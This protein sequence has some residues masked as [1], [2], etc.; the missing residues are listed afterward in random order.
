MPRTAHRHTLDA[1]VREEL[2][3]LVGIP[4]VSG[5]EEAVRAY[6]RQRLAGL[7]LA[8]E[9][10]A[11]GNLVALAPGVGKPLLL[12][13]HMDRVPPG[14]G[15]A[16]VVAN[17]IMRGDG[18]TNLGADDAAGLSII[19]LILE[20]LARVDA[21]HP[22]VLALFT[23]EE[24]IGLRGALAFDPVPW[25]VEEG[26]VFDNAGAA[27]SIVTRASTYI[28]F[29][30][31]LRGRGGHP[32]KELAGTVSA[33]E[34]LRHLTLP[35]GSLDGDTSRIS[36]GTITGGTARN[37]IPAEVEVTGEVRSLLQGDALQALLDSVARHFTETA[38]RLGGSATSAFTP[39]GAGYTIPPDEPLLTRWRAAWEARGL[40][41]APLTSTFIGSDTNALRRALRVFTVSTGV[42][43][44]HTPEESIALAPLSDLILTALDLL[45]APR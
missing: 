19:L 12:N 2:V 38:Q 4:S 27:G 35:L 14:R 18:A 32:G 45:R 41:P 1:R 5:H 22:P 43:D 26:I 25:N 9:V 29:D 34:M 31:L 10:D 16:P 28:A 42:E 20:E 30:A 11:V 13:A 37:A 15:H 33:I 44:E 39:H 23:V 21:P 6:L 7:G 24:E 40:G 8:S 36:L 3:A 17:G